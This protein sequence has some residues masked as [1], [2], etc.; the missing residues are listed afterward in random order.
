MR[1]HAW[2]YPNTQGSIF[3]ILAHTHTYSLTYCHIHIFICIKS[4]PCP[5]ICWTGNCFN[6]P[7]IAGELHKLT[8]NAPWAQSNVMRPRHQCGQR[9]KRKCCHYV[10]VD[11][12]VWGC[13][14]LGIRWGREQGIEENEEESSIILKRRKQKLWSHYYNTMFLNSLKTKLNFKIPFAQFW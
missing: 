11:V 1:N 2:V 7:E 8:R 6:T 4:W 9:G 14:S 10:C 12:C 13:I 5:E 3:A